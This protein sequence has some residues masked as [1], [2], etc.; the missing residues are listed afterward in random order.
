MSRGGKPCLTHAQRVEIARVI[1][2]RAEIRAAI[3]K[4]EI[5]FDALPENDELAA[6]YGVSIGTL[7]NAASH[8][9]A[10][11]HPLDERVG[12]SIDPR[13]TNQLGDQP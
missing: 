8:P 10:N 2:R 13:G 11:A 7:Y 1:L 6:Q 5:E 9:Y 12:A 4:L 3:K